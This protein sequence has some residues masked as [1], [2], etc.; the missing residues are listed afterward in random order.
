M[1]GIIGSNRTAQYIDKGMSAM[2]G[3]DAYRGAP[4]VLKKYEDMKI[5][6]V[7]N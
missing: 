5:K 1:S 6:I 4:T 7:Q 2:T 3:S